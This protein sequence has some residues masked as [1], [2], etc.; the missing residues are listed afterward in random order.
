MAKQYDFSAV[1]GPMYTWWESAGYFK[2]GGDASKPAYVV[3][4]PPP[5]VTGYLHMGHAMFVALQ[6]SR[7]DMYTALHCSVIIVAE[8]TCEHEQYTLCARAL[9][10][11][12][13]IVETVLDSAHIPK[14]MAIAC[15]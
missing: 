6:V 3:P 8:S 9:I 7:H 13:P 5:N 12:M 15:C 2:P 4:M 10:C 11:S 1:E 14:T